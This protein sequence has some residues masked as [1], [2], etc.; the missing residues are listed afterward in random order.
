NQRLY[1]YY[2]G[3]E[4]VNELDWLDDVRGD[5]KQLHGLTNQRL[6]ALYSRQLSAL[7]FPQRLYGL[8]SAAICPHNAITPRSVPSR[9]DPQYA[10]LAYILPLRHRAFF[11][12]RAPEM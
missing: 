1:G 5:H 2:E 9:K 4:K 10:A 3:L 8:S 11:P 12:V 6:H 7:S